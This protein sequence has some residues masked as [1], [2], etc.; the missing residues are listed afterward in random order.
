MAIPHLSVKILSRSNGQSAIAAASYRSGEAI[1]NELEK[2]THDFTRKQD[3]L[4][5]EI[6]SPEGYPDWV[7]DRQVL[8]NKVE[9]TEKRKDAQ[10]ARNITIALPRELDAEQN[11]ELMHGFIR[12]NFIDQGM[13]ADLC[14][15]N[16]RA[17]DGGKN[18]HAHIL[19]TMREFNGSGFGKKNR[20]W[21]D[22]KLLEKW[23]DSW[24]EHVNHHLEKAG[25]DARI[26]MQS[27]EKQGLD[28][29]A[30]DHMGPAAAQLEEQGIETAVGNHNR[31]VKQNNTVRDILQ[32][33]LEGEAETDLEAGAAEAVQEEQISPDEAKY[34][35]K[36]AEIHE[37]QQET[38]ERHFMETLL[39]DSATGDDRF[40]NEKKKEH[41]A[42]LTC[43]SEISI[44][45][46]SADSQN[47]S[48]VQTAREKHESALR[49]YMSTVLHRSVQANVELYSRIER[50]IDRSRE[51]G[52]SI[53]DRF[54]SWTDRE[55]Q[56]EE[57]QERDHER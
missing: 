8:W 15:H 39:L 53:F 57:K 20:E 16:A 29:E 30:T 12:E 26:S 40:A 25:H 32:D 54:T 7:H 27:Y 31:K 5:K 6:M 1:Y 44:S 52:R 38:L 17:S 9:A 49:D 28:K 10:L 18:P 22:V 35:A 14:I 48:D 24:E 34:Q 19:L 55:R 13:I 51:V 21:N 42:A 37:T 56:R 43:L 41:D 4:Y 23:R 2:K 3:V 36:L 47:E 45:G 50:F 33:Q 46:S 11:K